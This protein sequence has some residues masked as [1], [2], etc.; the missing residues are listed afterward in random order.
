MWSFTNSLWLRQFIASIRLAT[1]ETAPPRAEAWPEPVEPDVPGYFDNIAGI[2]PVARPLFHKDSR[3]GLML[4]YK[5]RPSDCLPGTKVGVEAHITAVSY[6]TTKKAR[7]FWLRLVEDNEIPEDVWLRFSNGVPYEIATK[8]QVEAA[9]VR[10]ALHQRFWK[11]P[12]HFVGLLNGD[13]LWN[14]PVLRYTY[15]GSGGNSLLLGVCMEGNFPG[16][17]KNRKAKHHGYDPHT[18]ET[19]RAAVR[20]AVLK[21]REAGEPINWLYAHRQYSGGRVGDPGEGWWHEIGLPCA[22]ELD[23]EI[24]YQFKHKNGL[25]VPREWDDNG[26]VDYRG[27]PL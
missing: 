21:G 22:R 13:V 7:K 23:L 15:H 6:G 11:V 26:L 19:G 9:V 27:R 10:M 4:P 24:N 2:G 16:L 8:E 25:L 20:L 3:T 12:Y 17:E 5:G 1:V 14:N 18:I